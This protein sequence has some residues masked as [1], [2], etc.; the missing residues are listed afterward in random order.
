MTINFHNISHNNNKLDDIKQLI[1][2][3]NFIINSLNYFT[4]IIITHSLRQS[5]IIYP[6]N[7]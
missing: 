5:I 6:E 4:N 7:L 1:I 3:N 2:D